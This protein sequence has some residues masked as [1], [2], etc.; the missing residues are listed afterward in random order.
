MRTFLLF[1]FALILLFSTAFAS[2][3]EKSPQSLT[4]VL[5]WFI[6]PDHAALFVADQQG[7]FKQAGLDV[8]LIAPANPADPPKLV[9][10]GKADIAVDYQ[11]HLLLEIAQGL[12][13]QQLGALID[14]PLSCLA[15]LI[16]SPIHQL[17]D[18]KGKRIAYSSTGIDTAMLQIML[19][20]SGLNLQDVQLVNVGYGLSQAL[21][22]KKV[23][24]AIG[25]MRNFELTQL[26]MAGHPARAFFP[27][28]NG[29]PPYDEL[30]L[31]TRNDRLQD[32]R[33]APFL[34]ALAKG[35]N[36]L[37]AH[38]EETWQAFAKAHPELNDDLNHKAWIDTLPFFAKQP[39]GFNV[40]RCQKLATALNEAL[41]LQIPASACQI[42]LPKN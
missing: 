38:P 14:H 30:V 17:A 25:L 23:D 15:V 2:T 22:S 3:T 9:A 26:A 12:P 7:Y 1:C 40:G 27:E 33:F 20:K 10:A 8:K 5:D 31:I 13:L 34:Q 6:N 39:A 29:F 36:Y 28:D 18:L 32:P 21:L 24:A 41:Q 16:D 42:T 4:V 35:V 11:P 37:Q 19:K